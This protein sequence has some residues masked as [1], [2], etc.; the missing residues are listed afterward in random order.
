MTARSIKRADSWLLV[1][2]RQRVEPITSN[3]DAMAATLRPALPADTSRIAQLLI[4][5]R[6]TFMPYAPLVHSQANVRARRFYER[7]GFRA[8]RLSDGRANEE[9]CPD[10]LYESAA[11]HTPV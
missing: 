10:V 3:V 2:T 7:Y 9:H 1:Y 5:V 11:V 4:D 6:S 8:I